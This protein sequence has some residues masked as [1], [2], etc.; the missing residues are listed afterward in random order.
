MVR[1][2][3]A[4]VYCF[5]KG[6]GE[7]GAAGWERGV[8]D[9]MRAVEE[10]VRRACGYEWEGTR[11]AVGTSAAGSAA[12][13]DMEAWEERSMELGFEVVDADAK[14]KN[15]FGEAVGMDRI[16]EALE[17]NDWSGAADG[18]GQG[19]GAGEGAEDWS[20][21]EFGMTTGP[22]H[23]QMNAELWGLKASLL[24]QDEDG[25]EGDEAAQVD[26][27]EQ[28]MSQVLAIKENGADMPLEQRKR[29]AAKA[30]NDL[31]KTV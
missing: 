20:E 11:L 12:M 30:V 16:R 7:G 29:Y 26:G 31:M 21:D 6:E 28:M 25:D 9:A 1:A 2:V 17:A 24:G 14:G 15:E 18:E 19:E 3:G 4:W 5:R 23:S 22:E 27:L 10:V 8:Q 13:L